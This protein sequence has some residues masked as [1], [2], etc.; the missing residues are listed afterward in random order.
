MCYN[1][2]VY[3]S[4]R[5]S[6]TVEV[7]CRQHTSVNKVQYNFNNQ[8]F[9][10]S[11][12]FT[13]DNKF[14]N[15][16]PVVVRGYD[17]HGQTWDITL[18]PLNFVWQAA[19]VNQGPQYKDGQKGAIIEMFGWPYADIKAECAALGKMGWMGVKVFPPQESVFSY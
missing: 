16:L 13:V 6:A 11:N 8:G 4:G 15:T 18:E 7:R 3:N 9:Q 5:T 2:I 17:I 19:N 1:N 12:K 14:S 10:D